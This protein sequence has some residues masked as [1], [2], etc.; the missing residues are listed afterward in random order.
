M[1]P[2]CH[3]H[4]QMSHS[5]CADSCCQRCSKA[6]SIKLLF[7]SKEIYFSTIDF[8]PHSGGVLRGVY[9]KAGCEGDV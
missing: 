5:G 8:A 1:M 3:C 6:G 7:T 2:L 4:Q 9:E